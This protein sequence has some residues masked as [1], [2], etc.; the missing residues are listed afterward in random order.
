MA[1]NECLLNSRLKSEQLFEPFFRPDFSRSSDTG[2]NGLGLAIC[3]AITDTNAWRLIW[4]QAAAGVHVT[5]FFG[6]A[7]IRGA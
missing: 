1:F 6:G 7:E 4:I 2:G 3:K 5:V